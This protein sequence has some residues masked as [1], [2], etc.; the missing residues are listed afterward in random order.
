VPTFETL[1]NFENARPTA[2]KW[3]SVIG[4]ID[5]QLT[6][7]HHLFLR[8]GWNRRQDVSQPFYGECCRAAGNAQ[9]DSSSDYF[10]RRNIIAAIS[11]TWVMNPRTVVDLRLGFYRYFDTDIDFGEGYDPAALGFPP[12]FTSSVSFFIFPRVLMT[13]VENLG[14]GEAPNRDA[15]NSFDPIVSFSSS[16]GRHTVKYGFR[17][18]ISQVNAWAAGRA[19]GQYRFD[20]TFTRGPDPT[21]TTVNAGH[22]F[23]SFLLG[24]PTQG[25]ADILAS[26][27]LI[28]NYYGFYVQDDWKATDRLTLNLGLRLEHEDGVVERYDRGSGGFDFGATSPIESAVQANYAK[29]PIPEL[30]AINVKGGLRFLGVDG[31]SREHLNMPAITYS[32]RVGF[33]YRMKDWMVWRGGWGIFL[34]P[35]QVDN[36]SQDGFSLATQMVTSLDGNLTPFRTLSDPFPSGLS[37][38]PGAARGLLTGLGQSLIAGA[39]EPNGVPRFRHA[40]SQQFSMGFQFALPGQISLETSYVGNVSQRLTIAQ[41]NVGSLVTRGRLV[42]D[43]PNEHLA[44]KTRLNAR[45]PNPFLGVITDPTSILSQPTITVQQ[46]LRPYPQFLTLTQSALPLGRSHY[47]SFQL[48]L[49]RRFIDGFYLGTSYTFSKYMDGTWYLNPNDAKPESVISDLDRPHRVVFTGLYELPIGRGKPFLSTA[50]PVI[51]HVLGDWQL[52][53]IVQFQSGQALGFPGAERTGKSDNDPGDIFEWFDKTQFVPQEPFTLRRTSTRLADLRGPGIKKWDF[54]VVRHFPITERVK[55]NFR[56]MFFN[57]WNTPHFGNPNTTVTSTSF[58]RITSATLS[59][60]IQLAGRL[61]F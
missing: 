38:P 7:N 26:R 22:D 3:S 12:S 61:S 57:A 2:L 18:R 17:G 29:N 49:S 24:T 14:T 34:A 43:F 40:I 10:D 54:T 31:A 4:R 59:R 60:E 37:Q 19:N 5:H 8:Y 13:D 11:D 42:N 44:L 9:G 39:A 35:N 45:V 15:T 28:N 51:R 25:F 58:G 27:T 50:H 21:R 56:A 36:F 48:N 30:A 6:N 23:A 1:Q 33:A 55:F 16:V 20:R 46:L 41:T 32:P 47:D 53:W 52:N